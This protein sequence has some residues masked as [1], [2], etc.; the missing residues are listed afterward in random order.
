MHDDS[1]GDDGD[2]RAFDTAQGEFDL[3]LKEIEKEPVPARLLELA[4]RLQAAL[5]HR[6]RREHERA[7]AASR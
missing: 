4:V 6:S 2:C 1:S 3:L 7:A 5:Q